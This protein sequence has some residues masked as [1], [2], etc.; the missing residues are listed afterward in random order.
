MKFMLDANSLIILLSGTSSQMLARLSQCEEEDLTISAIAFAEVALGSWRG[1]RP[2]LMALD[3]VAKRI[4]VL[5]FDH[6]AAKHYARLSFKRANF[7]R[8]IGAHALSL[9]LVLVTNNE[10][11][12]ADIPGLVVEN[13]TL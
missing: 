8:L 10:R 7:D 3:Q 9:G 11:D 4:P 5:S 1:K 2:P 6:V 13:W 12:F